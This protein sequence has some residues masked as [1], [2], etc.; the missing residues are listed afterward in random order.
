M[1]KQKI[2][3]LETE[4]TE[5]FMYDDK[6]ED[7]ESGEGPTKKE[8]VKKEAIARVAVLVKELVGDRSIRRTG[9][10]SGVA[11][12]YITGILKEKYLPSADILRKL[13]E[14]SANPQNGV[15]LEDLMIAAG[16]QNNYIEEVLNSD[17]YLDVTGEKT[18]IQMRF[19][20]GEQTDHMDTYVKGIQDSGSLKG[21][22][23]EEWERE[24]TRFKNL[25][26]GVIYK[27]LSE[28]GFRYSNADDVIGVRGF[29]PDMALYIAQQ[30]ILEWWFDLRYIKRKTFD[31][32]PLSNTE[33]RMC[34]ERLIFITPKMERKVSIV[35]GIKWVFDQLIGYKDKLAYRGDLSVIL[36]DEENFSV[37]QEVYLAHYDVQRR[38]SEFYII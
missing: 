2:T 30:P 35:T 8:Q 17:I 33:A 7:R 23:H 34:L 28:K 15:T 12:S 32:R 9:E 26:S 14:P 20:N 22:L 6:R 37:V 27:S 36:I 25:S 1:D 3:N 31:K 5:W 38:D 24:R 18:Q 10:D 11:A 13:T 4:S 21:R 19:L 29:R 16:Y